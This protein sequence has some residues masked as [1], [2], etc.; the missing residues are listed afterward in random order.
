MPMQ[1]GLRRSVEILLDHE[2][3]KATGRY[4]DIHISLRICDVDNSDGNARWLPDTDEEILAVGGRWDRK[5]KAW[6]SQA[7]ER[8]R[9]LRIPRGSDQEQPARW[10]AE[11]FRRMCQ[12]SK[13]A[14]W[15][16]GGVI[17][18]GR[19]E[20]IVFRRAWTLLLVG[21]R[22]G[23]KTHIAVVFLVIL[24][25]MIPLSKTVAV[26]PTQ[27][28][29]DELEQAARSLLPRQW[30]TVRGHGAGKDLQFKFANGSR[31]L[32]ISGHKPRGLKRGRIDMALYNEAQLQHQAGWKHLRGAV[33]DSG[34]LV[35][36]SCNPPDEPIGR[37]IEEQWERARLM[38][39]DRKTRTLA[40]QA[41]HITGKHNPFVSQESLEDM[42]AELDEVSARKD[43]DGEMGVPIGDV[44]WHAFSASKSVAD[45]PRHFLDI[46][47][48][49]TRKLGFASQ[50]LVGM[51]FQLTP[52]MC[53]VIMKIYQDPDDPDAERLIWVVDEVVLDKA[54]E[55]DLCDALERRARWTIDGP[56]ESD[57][58]RGWT[59]ADDKEPR[60][61]L[62]VMDASGF[63]QD[64]EHN[65]GK[66]SEMA[67][68]ARRWHSLLPPHVGSDRNPDVLERVK[69][70]NTRLK[71]ADTAGGI[72]RRR[73]FFVP[74]VK[75][76]IEAMLN[77][78]RKNTV[79]NR[80]S[81]FAHLSDAVS[82]PVFRIFGKPRIKSSGYSSS[83]RIGGGGSGG[84]EGG[85]GGAGSVF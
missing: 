83:G 82:Y 30:F 69:V 23:G 67:L 80:R 1:I 12:G 71:A 36:N 73:M 11:W 9:V 29:T 8:G 45:V 22:R 10:G 51:D 53:A 66:T 85:L 15:D 58:Y 26:S 84:D 81:Q 42:R 17:I 38:A 5:R 70:T 59:L 65:R 78:E 35:I 74:S 16:V 64:G 43:I 21:G 18:L 37:W 79:P 41:F 28:E 25:V 61:C 60:R 39:V 27:A 54:D 19:L 68:R 7:P 47:V 62:V 40:I 76:T 75:R 13:G 56:D 49:V 3:Q 44:V 4:V 24:C 46:T 32:F 52:A 2:R 34:G 63:F 20:P 72:G 55:Y 77:W 50:Y 57:C 48:D 6:S 33:V 14:H 31:I